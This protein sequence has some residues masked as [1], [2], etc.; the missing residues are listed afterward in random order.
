MSGKTDC[1]SLCC[2]SH[3]LVTVGGVVIFVKYYKCWCRLGGDAERLHVVFALIASL[4]CTLL[5]TRIWKYG[6][7]LMLYGTDKKPPTV[8]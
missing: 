1:L 2:G 6:S 7:V 3:R 8:L 4:I 5:D